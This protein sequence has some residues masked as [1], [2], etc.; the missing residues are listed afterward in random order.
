MKEHFTE[1]DMTKISKTS[2]ILIISPRRTGKTTLCKEIMKN[3]NCVKNIVF[4]SNS[5]NAYIEDETTKVY[6]TFDT[7]ILN[8]LLQT[9]TLES[10]MN[11]KIDEKC[12]VIDDC[13]IEKS[14]DLMKL[15]FNG[16]H[17]KMPFIYTTQQPMPLI[18]PQYRT[19]FDY[20]ILLKNDYLPHVRKIY[21]QYAGMFPT[22]DSF[23]TV[24]KLLTENYGAMIISNCSKSMDLTNIILR[25]NTKI[26]PKHCATCTCNEEKEGN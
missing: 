22:F 23:Y 10:E 5:D 12:V 19:G 16:R 2:S 15:I 6:N 14:E 25:Y 21:E 3:L 11:N 1:F 17:Y 26:M 8:S 4:N 18:Q 20:V 9:Q 7:T 24:F 13:Y